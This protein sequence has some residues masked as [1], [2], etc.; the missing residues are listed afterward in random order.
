MLDEIKSVSVV[1]PHYNSPDALR[2]AL[3][4]VL[5]QS[6]RPIEIIVVDDC[7]ATYFL[8]QL[9]IVLGRPCYKKVELK[10]HASNQ[11]AGAARN[12][13]IVSARGDYVALLDADDVWHPD[14]ILRQIA[15]LEK[16]QADLVCAKYARF[17]HQSTKVSAAPEFDVKK[18][19]LF[20][21]VIRNPV[22]TPTVVFRRRIG[23][24][25]PVHLRRCEDYYAWINLVENDIKIFI[26]N[27]VLA[28]GF[29]H[30]V[31]GGGLT[32]DLYLMHYAHRS[33]IRELFDKGVI[34]LSY[35]ALSF[36]SELGKF[37]LRRLRFYYRKI[38]QI[39]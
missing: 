34:P 13:G 23:L 9:R 3:I 5:K 35:Y 16:C 1:I 39:R 20:D 32:G 24:R 29:K 28:Y 33:C 27:D 26:N 25:F 22:K 38:F 15:V 4:S 2:R 10:V 11:G 14:L 8:S 19:T 21:F 7:S 37:Q 6:M 18:I 36:I 17:N 30:E 31:G 12:T